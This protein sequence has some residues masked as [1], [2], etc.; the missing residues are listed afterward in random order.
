MIL[1]DVP[2]SAIPLIYSDFTLAFM[3]GTLD[4]FPS[5]EFAY[6]YREDEGV[7]EIHGGQT[8][9]GLEISWVGPQ[10]REF[11]IQLHSGWKPKSATI[12]IASDVREVDWEVLK[13]E[14]IQIRTAACES[15]TLQ[16]RR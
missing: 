7:T 3:Y 9:S 10:L 2:D 14:V 5:E 8:D 12:T 16:F 13:G 11:I 6:R 1:I 4:I 15:A